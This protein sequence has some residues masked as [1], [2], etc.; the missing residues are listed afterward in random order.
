MNLKI[1]ICFHKPAK[2]IDGD[3][4]LPIHS[5]RV[6][7]KD[8]IDGKFLSQSDANWLLENTIGDDTGDNI[9]EKSDLFNELTAI[10]WAWKNYKS[11]E[12][13][14]P[15]YIGLMHYRRHFLIDDSN[16]FSFIGDSEIIAAQGNT[17]YDSMLSE[18]VLNHDKSV[19]D[20]AL[21]HVKN[22][23]QDIY[24]VAEEYLN[25]KTGAYF[26]MFIMKREIFFEYCVFLFGILDKVFVSIDYIK[27]SAYQ[28]RIIGFLAERLTGIFFYYKEKNGCRVKY[29][30][31][32]FIDDTEIFPTLYPIV[33]SGFDDT[34]NVA[35][36][37]NDLYS[38]HLETSIISFMENS[39]KKILYCIYVMYTKLSVNN[40]KSLEYLSKTY[41]NLEMVFIPMSSY[42]GYFKN[43]IF[44]QHMTI[45]TYFRFFIPEIFKNF[46]KIAWIDCD[47]VATRDIYDLYSIDLKT[48]WV[49]ACVDIEM[50]RMCAGEDFKSYLTETLH[51]IK[52]DNYFQAGVVIFNID[53]CK[54]NNLTKLLLDAH[55]SIEN[56]RYLDQDLLN[57]VC[58]DHVLFLDPRWN[59]EWH[60]E[61]QTDNIT[62]YLSVETYKKMNL[63]KNDPFIVHYC[64]MFKPWKDTSL[65]YAFLYW[66]Y[67]IKSPLFASYHSQNYVKY[68]KNE[69]QKER[70]DIGEIIPKYIKYYII[71]VMSFGLI[72]K[73][74]HK[75]KDLKE[76]LRCYSESK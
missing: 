49:A 29:E 24:D 13:K 65:P 46:K 2:K 1:M 68:Y 32:R 52:Y 15:D 66:R 56:P 23:S 28:S 34:V 39:S 38:M 71:N 45:E 75:L 61:F 11:E 3:I 26:N 22:Y 67:A 27:L 53:A 6:L 63:A 30:N 31:V 16:Y 47:V 20:N 60:V 43:D 62:K 73:W 44:N 41:N 7:L 21:N 64:S 54:K 33:R 17:S 18:F 72:G 36:A 14:D 35:M 12:L 9:S 40:K 50:A 51:I 5:G 58:Q 10:Y 48:N 25:K 57:V 74:K 76:K 70:L 4:F 59:F 69:V 19:L 8:K 42:V 55:R 37:T